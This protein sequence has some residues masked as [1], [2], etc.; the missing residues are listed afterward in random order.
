[1]SLSTSTR[2][3]EIEDTGPHDFVGWTSIWVA[4]RNVESSR[5]DAYLHDSLT[6][7]LL[8]GSERS[9][10]SQ[11]RMTEGATAH[12]AAL[13]GGH[14]TTW[15]ALRGHLVDEQI[16]TLMN[17]LSKSSAHMHV[18][19]D[20]LVKDHSIQQQVVLLGAGLDTRAW[21]LAFPPGIAWYEVDQASVLDF[22]ISRLQKAGAGM[23]AGQGS[24]AFPLKSA[25]Y[26]AVAADLSEADWTGA[27]RKSGWQEHLPTVWVA[28]G[29]LYYLEPK[30]VAALLKEVAAMSAVE[31]FL[32]A[33]ACT[34]AYI[35]YARQVAA[36]MESGLLPTLSAAVK[37]TLPPDAPIHF[38]QYNWKIQHTIDL[39]K[40]AKEL[41]LRLQPCADEP[42]SL[43]ESEAAIE[44]KVMVCS[45]E[46]LSNVKR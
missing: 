13:G 27:L 20:T 12:E 21:R 23:Q 24:N 45:T 42:R 30:A 46:A 14:V 22:K 25:S 29:L 26:T 17:D 38:Q 37:W 43:D 7:H 31:S 3:H 2:Y 34:T 40:Q 18:E 35:D 44:C 36:T 16:T 39:L 1:M 19:D 15:L 28:E 10:Q 32:I 41:G 5:P 8:Q 11:E 4:V 6:P 33:T 9:L